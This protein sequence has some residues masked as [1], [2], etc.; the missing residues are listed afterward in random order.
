MAEFNYDKKRE[1][2]RLAAEAI[3]A[4]ELDQAYFHVKEAVKY[5]MVLA[6]R[7]GGGVLGQAYV[8]N[9]NGLLDV[10]EKLQARIRKSADAASKPKVADVATETR[11]G[12]PG[13]AGDKDKKR[14]A[15]EKNTGIRLDDVKG[16]A[17][18]KAVVMDALINPVKHPDVYKTLKVKPGTGL[19]LYGPPGTGKTMFAK[20]I[21]NEMDT[22]FMHVKMS[23]L[24]SKYVGETEQNIAAMFKEARSYKRCVLFLDE[25]ES[26][27]RKRGNQK[28]N[29]VESFLVE[30]D[31]FKP[32]GESQLFV[33]LATNRPWLLDSALTRSGRISTHVYVDLPDRETRELIIRAALSDVPLAD[34]VDV[35]WL[36]DKTEGF[37]GAELH[38]KENGGGLCDLACLYAARRWIARREADG[39]SGKADDW[40]AVEPVTRADFDSAL[41]H[42]VPTSKR[43]ADIIKRNLAYNQ[44]GGAVGDDPQDDL[45]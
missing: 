20:A 22:A 45:E 36:A 34:D 14:W 27:L 24:K 8:S 43:D 25:C 18:A 7:C 32:E 33:L 28:V 2:E 41:A 15:V 1:H 29:A 37:S 17:E 11:G 38:H 3:D 23:D 26:L 9:A 30:L 35:G 4:G 19:L 39:S 42:V 6:T 21:A 44:S 5:T 10:A 40:N 31:G 16:L 13:G 12:E